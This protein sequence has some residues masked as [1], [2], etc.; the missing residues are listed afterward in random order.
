MQ[1]L[2]K[3]N[4]VMIRGTGLFTPPHSISNEE[5]VQAYN[6]YADKFNTENAE[7]ISRDELSKL[8]YSSAEFI[9]KASGIKHRYVM[10]KEGLLDVDRMMPVVPRRLPEELSISAEMAVAAAN[11]ALSRA[12]KRPDEVDLVICGVATS[13]RAWP[14]V[15]IEIQ[16]ALGCSGSAYDMSVACSS[17]TFAISN[18]IDALVAGTASCALVV[19]PEFFTPQLNFRDRDSHFIFGDVATAVV[20]E[21]EETA[22]AKQMFRVVDRKLK[23]SFS[24]NIRFDF[25]YLTRVEPDLT[26]ERFFETDQWFVQNGRK[27]FRELLPLVV[28][29]IRQ[30]L[31][32]NGIDIS[33]IQRMWLHQANINMNQFAA[34]KLL[35]R[36]AKAEEA[37]NVLAEYGNTVSAGAIVAFHKFHE[38]LSSGDKGLICS[39]GAGYSVGS[40]LVERV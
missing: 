25:S 22:S 7:A 28:D 30:Q 23:T 40:L 29:L 18:A 20:L 12:G 1:R 4:P 31:E 27:V 10:Y 39:F 35:G 2:S 19:N 32:D 21:R 33:D 38:D 8:Q 24:N 6:A 3:E 16:Q 34:Q 26:L 5:L 37:P 15:A 13:E 36:K 9:E 14:A 11:E 17:A